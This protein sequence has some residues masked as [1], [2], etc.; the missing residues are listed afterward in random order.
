VL[1]LAAKYALTAAIVVV[2]SEI[3]RRS[4]RLGALVGALP[5]VALLAL[6]WM[7][8]EHRPVAQIG[9]YA[10]YT[11]WY[12]IPTLPMFLC[13]PWLLGRFGF[14]PAMLGFSIGTMLIFFVFAFATR[15]FGIHLL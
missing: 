6:A 14:A 10:R 3:A 11:F 1:Y 2:V 4:G 7:H 8:V 9:N 15:R 12:V 13:F 5:L